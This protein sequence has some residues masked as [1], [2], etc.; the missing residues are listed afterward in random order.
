MN[1][2]E[3]SARFLLQSRCLLGLSV[4][5]F[6]VSTPPQ[7][8][9]AWKVI[10]TGAAGIALGAAW[11]QRRQ[12]QRYEPMA[13]V[14][15][16]HELQAF[17]QFLQTQS[18]MSLAAVS[19]MWETVNAQVLGPAET[20][21][22]LP[23][24][25]FDWQRFN[26]EPDQFAHLAIVGPTGSGKSTLAEALATQL[27]GTTI[28]IAPH[29]KPGDFKALGDQVYCGGRNY[30]TEKDKPG[31]FGEILNGSE[32]AF[33]VVEIIRSLYDEMHHRFNLF[34]RGEDVGP[35]VNVIWDEILASLDECPKALVPCLKRLLRESRKVGIRLIV[36][37]QDDQVESLHIKGNGAI[38]RNLT[39]VRLGKDAIAHAK[40]I[41]KET[42]A[43]VMAQRRPCLVEDAPAIVPEHNPAMLS[44]TGD[45]SPAIAPANPPIVVEPSPFAQGLNDLFNL[46]E[47]VVI[48]RDRDDELL[49]A[50]QA[51]G[52]GKNEV[53][54]RALKQGKRAFKAVP[55]EAINA[56]L[57]K[58]VSRGVGTLN[59]AN[60]ALKWHP[61]STGGNSA[62]SQ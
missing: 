23:A 48:G 55:T 6:L 45:T 49:A 62:N 41:G 38:R 18:E 31:D 30:G 7:L 12:H 8:G 4:F 43:Q 33:S 5:L 9:K 3:I 15:S 26:S 11:I 22:L 1:P 28:A 17:G 19:G 61:P 21:L 14:Y 59:R 34:D 13:G 60:G 56:L 37:P 10:A 35:F 54:A 16:Q 42:L 40:S 52:E 51:F 29:R 36:L 27:G 47:P 46:D 20:Q 32:Y 57:E 53:T 25:T 50:I 58:L 44:Q 2:R 39:Y 24:Q